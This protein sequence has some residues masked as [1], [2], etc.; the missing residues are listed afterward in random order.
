MS[1]AGLA[2]C[3]GVALLT[4]WAAPASA[5][6]SLFDTLG[7]A[8]GLVPPAANPPD[9]VRSSRPDKEPETLPVF[10]TPEEPRSRVKSA[11]ELKAMDADLERASRHQGRAVADDKPKPKRRAP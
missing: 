7:K 11:A 9:F 2:A 6:E 8:A 10:S 5:D 1:Q 3:A 4:L